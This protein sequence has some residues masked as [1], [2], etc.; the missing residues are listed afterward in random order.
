MSPPSKNKSIIIFSAAFVSAAFSTE[1]EQSAAGHSLVLE[2]PPCGCVGVQEQ[3]EMG[4][5]PGLE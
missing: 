1:S 2:V 5:N 3:H 4:F